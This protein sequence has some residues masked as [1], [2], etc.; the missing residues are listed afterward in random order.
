M[1]KRNWYEEKQ[2][3]SRDIYR[4]L[5]FNIGEEGKGREKRRGSKNEWGEGKRERILPRWVLKKRE[6]E[7]KRKIKKNLFNLL[8]FCNYSLELSL[9]LPANNACI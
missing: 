7:K 6:K 8:Y 2:S 9:M 5:K 4:H 3:K 1:N